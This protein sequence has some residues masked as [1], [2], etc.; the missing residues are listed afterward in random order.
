[1]SPASLNA[2]NS[3][4]LSEV[5][6]GGGKVGEE[7]CFLPRLFIEGARK[8]ACLCVCGASTE[9]KTEGFILVG[10]QQLANR[11]HANPSGVI[12]SEQ[13]L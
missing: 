2:K 11:I 13:Q 9:Q 4:F 1:M 12:Y 3:P 7:T 5:C 10:G 6:V 8:R